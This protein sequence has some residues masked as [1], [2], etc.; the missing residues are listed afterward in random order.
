MRLRP[1][2][3]EVQERQIVESKSIPMPDMT[4]F[5]VADDGSGRESSKL[6]LNNQRV[7]K[8]YSLVRL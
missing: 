2:S 3:V 8:Y 4:T 5:C 1:T 7:G 6:C